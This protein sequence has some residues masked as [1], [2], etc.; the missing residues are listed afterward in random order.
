[1]RNFL[2]FCFYSSPSSSLILS[3]VLLLGLVSCQENCTEDPNA[4]L[5]NL[6]FIARDDGEVLSLAVDVQGLDFTTGQPLDSLLF[7]QAD[8]LSSFQLPISSLRDTVT[9]RFQGVITGAA[10]PTLNEQLTLVYDRQVNIIEPECGVSESIFNLRNDTL[11]TTFPINDVMI[12]LNSL[13]NETNQVNLQIILD[14]N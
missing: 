12:V 13:V 2:L 5:I 11:S 10:N 3:S 8:T 9:F 1:M 7:S 4:N 6:E 14:A